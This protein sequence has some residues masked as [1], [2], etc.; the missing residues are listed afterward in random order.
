MRRVIRRGL[1]TAI[2]ALPALLVC[3]MLLAA[4]KYKTV[5]WEGETVKALSGKAFKVKT[6]KEDPKGN[7][8]S[9]QKV[10]AIPKVPAGEK[11]AADEVT[12]KVNI[13]ETGVY[14]LWARCLWS[15][16]CGNSFAFKVEGNKGEYILGGDA[17]YD[18]LE[19]KSLSDDGGRPRPLRLQKGTITFTLG[20]KESGT[21]VDE[22]MLTTDAKKQP[23]GA[24]APTKNAL[25][26]D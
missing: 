18:T 14:Y 6:Y 13:P 7:D 22:F 11:V 15:T 3:G 4:P 2:M 23:A 9:G 1:Q 10:L 25:K 20:S 16:G 19:W 21:M 26:L 8:V 12:Y 5:V 17:T 24:Y